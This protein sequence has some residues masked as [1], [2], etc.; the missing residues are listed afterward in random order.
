MSYIDIAIIGLVV[1]TCLVGLWKGFFKTF[2]GMFGGII[3]LLLAIFL[4]KPIAEACVDGFARNFVLGETGSIRSF[5]G[6]LLPEAV[7]GLG[8]AASVTPEALSEALGSGIFGFFLKPFSGL[9]LGNQMVQEALTVYD[10]ITVLLS[11]L[12]FSVIVGIALFIIARLLMCLFTMFAK[13]FARDG[14]PSGLSRL[15]GGL[16]GL[17]RG[18]LYAGVLLLVAS[19]FTGF[20]FMSGYNAELDKSVI[21]KPVNEFVVKLPDK[22]FNDEDLFSKL[23]DRAGLSKP[24]D[25]G[26][27]PNDYQMTDAEQQLKADFDDAIPAS[28][29]PELLGTE[30]VGNDLFNQPVEALHA[31]NRM[32]SDRLAS[33][34]VGEDAQE[35]CARLHEAMG[36]LKD[37]YAA[38]VSDLATFV[39][40]YGEMEE[41]ARNELFLRIRATIDGI[42]AAYNDNGITAQFGELTIRWE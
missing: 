41:D 23:L 27:K 11:M 29:L 10:G 37:T 3:A 24:G 26:E 22:L 6:G 16:L 8:Q 20:P 38:L 12:I 7:K 25:E 42:V 30:E 31:Y 17:A 40:D 14:K 15:L 32:A 39:A 9:L 28:R 21:A 2:I 34:G 1:L 33:Q 4:A 19:V 5:V 35:N 36:A 18:V 13:S